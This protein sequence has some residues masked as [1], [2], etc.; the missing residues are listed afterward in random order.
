MDCF[1]LNLKLS[2]SQNC[3]VKIMLSTGQFPFSNYVYAPE[4]QRTVGLWLCH[5]M[6]AI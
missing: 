2:F 3:L 1:R 5:K 4:I 6:C